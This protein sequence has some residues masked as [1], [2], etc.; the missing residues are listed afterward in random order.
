M[1]NSTSVHRISG[2]FHPQPPHTRYL[3]HI[4]NRC[5]LETFLRGGLWFG[6]LDQF[7]D[8]RE[9]TLP[10]QNLGLLN[11]LPRIQR[12]LVARAYEL[13]V[14]R[15]FASCWHMSN[16]DPS[17]HAW[18]TFGNHRD[19]L[20]I[21]T[22]GQALWNALSQISGNNGPV[23]LG[24]VHYIDHFSDTISEENVIEAAFVVRS[25]FCQ[26]EEARVLIHTYG[27]AAYDNLYGKRGLFGD[28]VNTVSPTDSESGMREFTGGHDSGRAI[29]VAINP[30][31]LIQEIV[32]DQRVSDAE[33]RIILDLVRQYQLA[34][35][36]RG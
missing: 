11:R 35:R 23:Y 29:V 21:R 22:T 2:V 17:G 25:E 24:A 12:P 36:I 15:S 18:D 31:D 27:T 13:A 9:G 7:G 19:G 32:I 14:E 8:P 34:D 30:A 28:L 3:W 20:A 5:K 10:S 16:G 33:R 1:A 26:E 6:R 4:M